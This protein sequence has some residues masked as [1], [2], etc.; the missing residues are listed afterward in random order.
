MRGG[1]VA[2]GHN[3]LRAL[4]SVEDRLKNSLV[5]EPEWVQSESFAAVESQPYRPVLPGQQ[6]VVEIETD[7]FGLGDHDG[8]QRGALGATHGRI[9]VVAALGRYTQD[10]G[11]A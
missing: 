2:I 11:L 7:P 8:L 5:S 1:R 6:A 4:R 10:I 3:N 9:E